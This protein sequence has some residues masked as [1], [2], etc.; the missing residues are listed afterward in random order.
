MITIRKALKD[1]IGSIKNLLHEFYEKGIVLERSEEEILRELENFYIAEYNDNFAGT[2]SF[3]NYGAHLKE[4]RSLV[5]PEIYRKYG[6]GRMLVNR[7]VKDILEENSNQRIFTLTYVPDFFQKLGFYI[8][9]KN[10]FPE[11]I[12]K[13]CVNCQSQDNCGETALVFDNESI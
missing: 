10:T 3:H 1:D 2:I 6:I 13:D 12:W 4:I 7:A 8:V 5:V 11:K 9:D